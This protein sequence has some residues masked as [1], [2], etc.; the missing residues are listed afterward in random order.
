MHHTEC[1]L[2]LGNMLINFN[3]ISQTSELIE[4]HSKVLKLSSVGTWVDR[5]TNVQN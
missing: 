1:L 2:L 3:K 4:I 5:E